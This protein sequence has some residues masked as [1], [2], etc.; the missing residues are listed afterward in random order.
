M[1]LPWITVGERKT[2]TVEGGCSAEI[3]RNQEKEVAA[4]LR[5]EFAWRCPEAAISRSGR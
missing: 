2:L 1:N 4:S 5:S 3:R